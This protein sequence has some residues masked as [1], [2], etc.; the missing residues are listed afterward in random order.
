MWPD[1]GLYTTRI[2][3]LAEGSVVAK[4][5]ILV[6]GGVDTFVQNVKVA[7]GETNTW[8][9]S[10]RNFD[11]ALVSETAMDL[12]FKVDVKAAEGK[13]AI[14]PLTVTVTNDEG[15]VVGTAVTGTGQS[16]LPTSSADELGQEASTPS[17]SRQRR[18]RHRRR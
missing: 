17:R 2:D 16:P 13:E 12:A 6:E 10:V 18:G 7:P 15:A 9:F 1:A 11:G 14:A 4:E 5:F 8:Q 3:D